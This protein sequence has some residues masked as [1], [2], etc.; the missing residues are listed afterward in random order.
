MKELLNTWAPSDTTSGKWSPYYCKLFA[1]I[2]SFPPATVCGAQSYKT[3]S[4]GLQAFNRAAQDHV[5]SFRCMI[6]V[7]NLPFVNLNYCTWFPAL[8]AKSVLHTLP[9]VMHPAPLPVPG[10]GSND[11][12]RADSSVASPTVR[13]CR[14]ANRN[15]ASG[16]SRVSSAFGALDLSHG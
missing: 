5:C 13:V 11:G 7:Y 4:C 2:H 16:V 8:P 14:P 9:A 10:L 3:A 12:S 6:R 15:A 1:D